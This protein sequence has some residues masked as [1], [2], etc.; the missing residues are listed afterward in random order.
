MQEKRSKNGL[1]TGG[2]AFFEKFVIIFS[3]FCE[4]VF[5]IGRRIVSLRAN[6]ANFVFG[7]SITIED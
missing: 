4:N 7:C 5:F 2:G 6:L 3:F 1:D